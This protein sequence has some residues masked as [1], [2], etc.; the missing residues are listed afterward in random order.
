MQACARHA[1]KVTPLE[2]AAADKHEARESNWAEETCTRRAS[3]ALSS[4]LD[5]EEELELTVE[6]SDRYW[7]IVE[8][9]REFAVSGEQACRAPD[10]SLPSRA[11]IV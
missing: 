6:S 10:P 11:T 4:S 9:V 5:N 8:Y 2:H 1:G 7:A 3:A